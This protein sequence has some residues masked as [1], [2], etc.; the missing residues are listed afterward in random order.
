MILKRF[1]Y[2]WEIHQDL[3]HLVSSLTTSNVHD[4]VTVG[5]LGQGLRNDSLA[6]SESTGNAHSA[7]L[8]TGEKR[9]EHTLSDNQRAVRRQLLGRRT[10]NTH[11]PAVH[12]AV[13]GLGAVEVEL[14]NLL[15]DG[16]AALLGDAGDGTLGAGREQDLVLAEQTV[17]EDGAKDITSSDVVAD[18]ELAG[19]KVPLLL[20]VEGGQID[21]S[22]DVDAVCVVGNALER[23]LDAVVDGLHETGAELDGQGQSRHA[24]GV[25]DRHTSC[26]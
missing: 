18:L 25:A 17:L 10:G 8:D 9:V 7:T 5:E 14:Q 2:F 3:S 24:Y 11:G 22:G 19:C 23:A 15:V 21:T 4:N 26:G 12:H 13:L 6:A 16:V 1:T 20:A